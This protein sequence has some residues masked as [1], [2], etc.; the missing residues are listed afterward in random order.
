MAPEAALLTDQLLPVRR[1]PFHHFRRRAPAESAD[2]RDDLPNLR[3]VEEL[4]R[5]GGA[6]DAGADVAIQ[7]RIRAPVKEDSG[8]EVRPGTSGGLRAVARRTVRP[9]NLRARC[10]VRGSIVR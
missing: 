9:E 2:V 10:A 3:A 8:G 5:H 4:I 1:I 7:L 6:G